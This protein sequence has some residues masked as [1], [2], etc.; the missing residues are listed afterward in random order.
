MRFR[1]STALITAKRDLTVLPSLR[2]KRNRVMS[3]KMSKSLSLFGALEQTLCA[4]ALM[5]LAAQKSGMAR[6][7]SHQEQR[8][9]VLPFSGM[10]R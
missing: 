7:I 8:F 1:L 5:G 10:G 4:S 6:S 9:I 3:W 2:F